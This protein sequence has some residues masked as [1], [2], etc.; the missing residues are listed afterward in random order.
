MSFLCFI[1]ATMYLI[2]YVPVLHEGYRAF[3][4]RYRGATLYLI[5]PEYL[6]TEFPRLGRDLRYMPISHMREAIRGLGLFDTVAPL[7]DA[8]VEAIVRE[9]AE[10]VMPVDELSEV[11]AT[12]LPGC[13]VTYEQVFLRW[14]KPVTLAEQ[15][16]HPNRLV[17]EREA[18][19]EWMKLAARHAVKSADWWRQ[20]GAV[21]VAENGTVLGAGFNAHHPSEHAVFAHG[22]PR[23]NVDAGEHLEVS[24]TLHGEA[25]VVARAARD[26]VSL[27]GASFYVTTFPC[28]HCAR[29]LAEAG[30]KNVYYRDGYSRL[31]AEGVLKDHGMEII[32]VI[33]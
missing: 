12:R 24:D 29:L 21:A 13:T 22:N 17:S 2:T 28:I 32:R 16:V 30:V 18:D 19:R 10:V 9:R 27:M 20:V 1:L 7:T 4:E 6:Q 31:D 5:S 3:F 15:E 23:D 26:G 11:M 25:G 14:D 8:Y 33:P